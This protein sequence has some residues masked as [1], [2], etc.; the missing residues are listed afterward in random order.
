MAV[1][2]GKGKMQ[3]NKLIWLSGWPLA[4][5]IL[6]A[7]ATLGE[8]LPDATDEKPFYK[9]RKRGWYWYEQELA[10]GRALEKKALTAKPVMSRFSR[11][12]LWDMDAETLKAYADTITQT[13]VGRPSEENVL[14]YL[15]VQDVIRR[16]SLAF[17]SVVGMMGQKYPQ[18]GSE[19][20]YPT[21][22]PGQ[23]ALTQMRFQE[24]DALIRRVQDQFALIF[25]TQPG[26]SFCN[27]QN[28]ILAFFEE[29]YQWPVRQVDITQA[30]QF[31]AR[32]GVEIT[33]SV[34]IVNKHS[35]DHMPVSAG[36]VSL[37]EF[38]M[39]IFRAVRLMKKVTLP[40]QWANYDFELGTG[41]DPLAPMRSSDAEARDPQGGN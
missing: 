21:T 6:F 3:T 23:K 11:Q 32:F 26:C 30:P 9:D 37:A 19:D 31:A 16:K 7:A 22:L 36:V 35:R 8:T 15:L 4:V 12:E 2:Q 29:R 28:G 24:V 39:R 25:F 1:K 41:G 20:V 38:K 18:F 33:P 10:A 17:A 5:V 13:A 14:Q 27:A 34:I 40:E